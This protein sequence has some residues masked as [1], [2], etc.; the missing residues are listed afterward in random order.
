MTNDFPLGAPTAEQRLGDWVKALAARRPVPGGG[1]AAAVVAAAGEA[2]AAMA[3]AYSTGKAAGPRAPEHERLA[4]QYAEAAAA[5]L[6]LADADGAAFT[7]VQALGR[8]PAA[9]P[10][11]K[12]QATDTA[13]G[14][15]LQVIAGVRHQLA[16]LREFL[17]HCNAHLRAD[18]LAAIHLL[19]GAAR[20]AWQMV[21]VNS[22]G[23]EERAQGPAL[24]AEL[25]EADALAVKSAS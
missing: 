19:T 14:V 21:L 25:A 22:P 13:R 17:P 7:K 20:A 16:R 24:L 6:G 5:C 15:P 23:V 12:Q 9:D 11:K 4:A 18:A 10:I 8:D 1:A 2:L 3:I